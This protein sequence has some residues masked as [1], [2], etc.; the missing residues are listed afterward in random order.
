MS[1]TSGSTTFGRRGFLKTAAVAV[2]VSAAAVSATPVLSRRRL[3]ASGMPEPTRNAKN[4]IFMVADGM[5]TGT[6]SMGDML[7]RK[8]RGREPWW[9]KVWAMPGVRRAMQTT[10]CAD[11]LVTDSAAAASTWG[12]GHKVNIGT[13]NVLPDGSQAMPILVRAMQAGLMGGLVTT[14]RITHATPAG[15]VVNCPERNL[16]GMIAQQMIERGVHV[17]MGGGDRFF[18][19][20]LLKAHPEVRVVRTA[21]EL[22]EAPAE[23]R[24]LG[25]FAKEHVPMVLDRGPE[26][27]GL[28]TMT[29]SALKRLEKAERGFVL[30]VEG[31]RVDHAAHNNDAAGLVTEQME[32]DDAIGVVM[33]WMKGRDD[34]LLVI[35]TDHGN[36]NPGLTDYGPA[37]RKG[38]DN[39]LASKHSFEWIFE[40][41]EGKH[42]PREQVIAKLPGLVEEAVGYAMTADDVA[43]AD[44]CLRGVR[45][46]PWPENSKI[47]SVIGGILGQHFGIGFVSGNHTGDMV[48]LTAFGPGSELVTPV[49]DN[50]AMH[51]VMV[52]ALGLPEA[53]MLPGMEQKMTGRQIKPD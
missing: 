5:S 40:H 42:L 25:L 36:A 52:A 33:E 38:F 22:S 23:G 53:K 18:S 13:L 30:Q 43:F 12:S 45:S 35:T 10:H 37:S 46:H 20:E 14:T 24:L 39:L 26:V 28:A 4:V 17:L 6:L 27:P 47:T 29:A 2:G 51:G 7:I 21:K 15:F 48:E 32:F 19:A 16:E 49:V 31:G 11:S 1:G 50:T 44:G 34:T 3:L 9:A 8:H 41:V